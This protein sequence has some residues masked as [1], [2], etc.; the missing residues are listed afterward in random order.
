MDDDATL[1]A[2][3]RRAASL[4]DPVP[5]ELVRDA[6]VAYTLRAVDAELAELT[7]DSAHSAQPVRAGEPSRV[8]TFTTSALAIEVEIIGGRLVGQLLPAQRAQ[9]DVRR[10]D[11]TITVAAD[12][13]GRFTAGPF[14][15]G[16]FSLRCRLDPDVV[17]D[18]VS[19][20]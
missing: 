14:R 11:R 10:A 12:E 20:R 13:L 7:F 17:T 1:E 3:L 4:F 5:A 6:I 8:L 16:P 15:T 9:V 2:D 19:I 18:W